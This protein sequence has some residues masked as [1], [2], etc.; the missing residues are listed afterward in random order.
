[1][2][3]TELL[4]KPKIVWD[5]LVDG[6]SSVVL[7]CREHFAPPKRLVLHLDENGGSEIFSAD[8]ILL[9]SIVKEPTGFSCPM[10]LRETFKDAW[11]ETVL[12]R[13]WM[14]RRAL[15]PIATES[16]PFVEALARHQIDRLTPWR[17]ADTYF[18]VRTWPFEDDAAKCHVEVGVVAKSMLRPHLDFLAQAGV[19]TSSLLATGDQTSPDFVI[20][21]DGSADRGLERLRRQIG[22]GL[23][24]CMALFILGFGVLTLEKWTLESTIGTLDEEIAHQRALLHPADQM[25][26]NGVATA[27]S[28]RRRHQAG[29]CFVG[30]LDDLSKVLPDHAH[31]DDFSLDKGVLR[32]SGVSRHVSELVP[33]LEGTSIFSEAGFTGATTREENGADRFHLEMRI[34]AKSENRCS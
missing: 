11:V 31:L 27:Q 5:W 9:G 19:A 16:L 4:A 15:Q 8:G 17:A 24:G 20:R 23:A 30:I 2:I 32:I 1:M 12:P 22:F 18:G 29:P 28:L 26:D 25:D 7:S 34:V 14:L 6:L 3:D 13:G 33:L 21:I 10:S